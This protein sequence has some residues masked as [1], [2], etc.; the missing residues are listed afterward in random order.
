MDQNMDGRRSEE[1]KPG[2]VWEDLVIAILA[3]GGFPSRAG[4]RACYTLE[5]TDLTGEVDGSGPIRVQVCTQRGLRERHPAQR[6]GNRLTTSVHAHGCVC[7]TNNQ[8]V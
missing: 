2:T 7:A 4:C 8:S 5:S 3:V 6:P 1:L